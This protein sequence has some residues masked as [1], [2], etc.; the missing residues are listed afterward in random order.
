MRSGKK[1]L[2]ITSGIAVAGMSIS[3]VTSHLITATLMKVALHRKAPNVVGNLRNKLTRSPKT[4]EALAIMQACA[5]RLEENVSEQIEIVSQDGE[6]LIG[7]WYP[8]PNAKRILVAMHGWRSSWSRD[9]GGISTFWHDRECSVLYA[10]QRGQNNSSGEYIT[11]GFKE[12]Y[13][14]LEWVNWVVE[15]IDSTLP[16]YL[17]GISMGASTVLM[18]SGLPLPDAVHGIIADCGFT[19]PHAIWRHVVKNNLHL[20]Y[21]TRER[22]MNDFYQKNFQTQIADL[23]TVRALERNKIPVLFVHGAADRFV[24]IE[25]TYQNYAACQAPKRLLVVPD[26]RHGMSYFIDKDAYERVTDDFW[27]DFD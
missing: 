15:N 1:T 22:A 23:S 11:F 16:I 25:M 2:L 26:A 5:E 21:Y 9:F 3:L 4:K 18:A 12:R 14:C 7:H 8:C 24:P 27:R 10:E 19:S 13:D 20:T 17:C 6:R